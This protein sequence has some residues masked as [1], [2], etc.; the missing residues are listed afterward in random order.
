MAKSHFFVA[1][2][3]NHTPTYNLVAYFDDFDK[4]REKINVTARL[5]MR[6]W[7][8]EN[9][10]SEVC[11]RRTNIINLTNFLYCSLTVFLLWNMH[12]AYTVEAFMY[13]SMSSGLELYSDFHN[14]AVSIWGWKAHWKIFREECVYELTHSSLI[15]VI[16]WRSLAKK[17]VI[18]GQLTT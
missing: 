15:F 2:P 11:I 13:F 14:E 16:V 18:N 5:P 4:L 12:V 17:I 10:I 3:S 1:R 9:G 6:K 7:E 8:K